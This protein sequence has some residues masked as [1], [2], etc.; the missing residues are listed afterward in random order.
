MKRSTNSHR[1]TWLI[2]GGAFILSGPSCGGKTND[3]SGSGG[4]ST[5]GE[6][7]STDDRDDDGVADS[8]GET[9]DLNDDGAP[10]QV[11]VDGDG[12]SDGIAVDTDSD[13]QPDGA[14]LDTDDDGIIDAIDTDGDGKRDDEETTSGDGDGDGDAGTGGKST[15]GSGGSS[16]GG[17]LTSAGGSA[18]GGSP[19]ENPGVQKLGE[20]CG[21]AGALACAGENQ[22][23]Q[24]LCDGSEW[25]QNGTC[26]GT[27]VCDT[28]EDNR[29]SCQEPLEGCLDKEP[30]ETYCEDGETR[31]CGLDRVTSDLVE[32][33]EW[34]CDEVG[35]QCST[36]QPCPAV[37]AEQLHDCTGVCGGDNKYCGVSEFTQCNYLDLTRGFASNYIRLPR[38][39]EQCPL[40]DCDQGTYLILLEPWDFHVELPEGWSGLVYYDEF[41]PQDIQRVR[42]CYE[43]V[44]SGCVDAAEDVDPVSSYSYVS[45]VL[46][47]APDAPAANIRLQ[48]GSCA[49]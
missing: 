3:T 41:D 44:K 30:G 35:L 31:R 9:V 26:S 46:I 47:A 17:A 28:D 19:S 1:V 7:G 43:P 40:P 2:L 34:Y 18:S 36:D 23:L 37:P 14:G 12:K 8:L 32:E 45:L 22:K 4:Q 27:A 5:S 11:D 6:T 48:S 20:V 24:L 21:D 49:D 39:A 13:G 29:G 38:G 16:T 25:V 10:D 42:G 15:G 33:C